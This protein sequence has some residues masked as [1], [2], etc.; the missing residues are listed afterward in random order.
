[1]F[2]QKPEYYDKFHC[3]GSD[4]IFTCC[5]GWEIGLSEQNYKC[6]ISLPGELG[7]IAK[8]S[9]IKDSSNKYTLTFNDNAICPYYTNDGLCRIVLEVGEH[10]ISDICARFPRDSVFLNDTLELNMTHACPH[11]AELLRTIEFP[12][13]FITESSRFSD[14]EKETPAEIEKNNFDLQIRNTILS[15]LQNR[16]YSLWFRL[17]GIVFALNKTEAAF[18]SDC[19]SKTE[20]LLNDFMSENHLQSLYLSLKKNQV[21]PPERITF[22]QNLLLEYKNALLCAAGKGGYYK[23]IECLLSANDS[24]SYDEYCLAFSKYGLADTLD[25]HLAAN[26]WYSYSL[27]KASKSYFYDIALAVVLEHLLISHVRTLAAL[28]YGS[29]TEDDDNFIIALCARVS[30]HNIHPNLN[31]IMR[32]KNNESLTPGSILYMLTPVI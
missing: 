19:R 9:I 28:K 8:N 20:T 12:L 11:V 25:E 4:C 32:M 5:T 31:L 3:I 17:F 29:I 26:T 18:L 2:I 22:C 30:T 27:L 15:L 14:Y 1:M 6:H 13:K 23:R 7:T 24:I 21:L 10:A 16:T